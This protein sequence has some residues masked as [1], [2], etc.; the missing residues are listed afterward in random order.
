MGSTPGPYRHNKCTHTPHI[1][2]EAKK[3]IKEEEQKD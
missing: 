2:E 1:Q 3:G